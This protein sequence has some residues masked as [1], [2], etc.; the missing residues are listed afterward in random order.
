MIAIVAFMAPSATQVVADVQK[1][2]AKLPQ[3]TMDFTQKVTLA[4]T[5]KTQTSQG[6]IQP[7]KAHDGM[8]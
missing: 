6:T 3:L 7:Q 5:G 8:P 4:L 1:H 2:Y